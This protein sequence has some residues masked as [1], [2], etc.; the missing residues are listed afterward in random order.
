MIA[1]P[2]SIRCDVCGHSMEKLNDRNHCKYCETFQPYDMAKDWIDYILDKNIVV[3]EEK[4]K[5]K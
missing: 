1:T 4:D 5:E 3:K 2:L